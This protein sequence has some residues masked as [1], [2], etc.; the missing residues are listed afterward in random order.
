[1]SRIY[2]ASSWRNLKQIEVVGELRDAGHDVYD[3]REPCYAG[4]RGCSVTVGMAKGGF[5]WKELDPSWKDW[6][7]ATY[8]DRLLQSPIAAHGFL[9]D[10]RAMRWADTFVLVMPCGR[11][12]HL[13][14]GW[15]AGA[16]KRTIILLDD[17]EPELMN[18]LAD[19]LV[20][21]VDELVML[22]GGQ[23]IGGAA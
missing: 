17:G 5:D 9:S 8:R 6:D 15:A 2:V 11:S 23:G 16:G 22:L 13:E 4:P 21:S 1:M 7:A 20:V 3:Y 18:L 14:A 10:L 12:A 19:E